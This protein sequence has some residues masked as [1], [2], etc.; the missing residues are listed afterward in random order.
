[1]INTVSIFHLLL[2]FTLFTFN[3][4]NPYFGLFLGLISPLFLLFYFDLSSKLK[5]ELIVALI[6]YGLMFKTF[7]VYYLLA[8]LIPVI[9]IIYLKDKSEFTAGLPSLLI[10]SLVLL[11]F[12]DIR[13]A[14]ISNMS[15]NL[16]SYL[17]MIKSSATVD[18]L[19]YLDKI[20]NNIDKIATTF[21]YI[22]PG[23]SFA[24][25]TFITYLNKRFYQKI[26]KEPVKPLIVPFKI[27]PVFVIGGFLILA[28]SYTAKIISYNTFIIFFMFFFL[29]G[30]E[31]IEYWLKKLK[32]PILLKYI[33][34]FFVILEPPITLIVSFIGLF[35]I[36]IDFRKINK[37][38]G[39]N[40]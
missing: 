31:I 15:Q 3:I 8:V 1:M 23:L 29:Q 32:F 12:Q 37:K 25:I 5:I 34:Y 20:K 9:F 33:V 27:I 10:S 21:I 2:S 28:N 19:L 30:I 26:K 16:L 4:Y 6:I 13:E 11:F 24:Y 22:M 39:E 14:F 35:D 38:G 18:K 7:L 17:E 36:W 40:G